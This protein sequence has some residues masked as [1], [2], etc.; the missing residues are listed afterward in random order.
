MDMP[1]VWIG[2]FG[3]N[4]SLKLFFLLL[5]CGGPLLEILAQAQIRESLAGETAAQALKESTQAQAQQY[6]LHYGP[7]DFQIGAG[8]RFGYTD[9]VF[10][11]NK[12]RKDDFLVNP[13][14]NLGGFVQVSERN[15][16][17]FSLGLGY[18]YYAKNSVLN[19]NAPLVNPDSELVFNLFVGN[20][21]IRLHEKFSY[22]ETLFINT[23]PS[24]QDLFFNFNDVGRFSRWDNLAGFNVDWDL[25]RIILSAGY[26]HENFESTT[27]SFDYLNRASEWLTASASFLIGD[28]AKVGL[29]SEGSFHN[30][31]TETVMNDHWQAKA[32]PFVD[33]K[34]QEKVS[35]RTGGGYDTALY[36]AAGKNSDFETYYAYGRVRQETRFFAHALSAGHEHLLG[37]NAN[38]LETTYIRYSISSPVVEHVDLGA[39]AAVHF[40][41]E[42]GGAFKENFTYY[43]VGFRV[44]Y[45]FHKYWRTEVGY[46]FMLKD[47]DLA[48]RDFYR[49]RVTLGVTFTF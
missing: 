20:F 18:E 44:G 35:F 31:E 37:D 12:D 39:N 40:A 25:N 47:S 49:D 27:A 38:N 13:E 32:G 17:R 26:E 30:F 1:F 22:Q 8:L 15:A 43:V 21:R 3:S 28:Q 46:E 24:R 23:I 41:R 10:Y 9:N 16:L 4:N 36:D 48:L 33:V 29:E 5:G 42:F 11:S 34:L 7:M 6:N 2:W 14:V 19:G 45:Q